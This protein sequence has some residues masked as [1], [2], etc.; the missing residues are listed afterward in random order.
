MYVGIGKGLNTLLVDDEPV[1]QRLLKEVLDAEGFSIEI[2][3]SLAG[4]RQLISRT[5]FDLVIVD[6]NLPD[7]SG[8][9][10][11]EKLFEE[12]NDCA[13]VVITGYANLDSAIEAIRFNVLDYLLK[14]IE[15]NDFRERIR[16]VVDQLLLRREHHKAIQEIDSRDNRMVQ[17]EA[18]TTRDPLTRLYNHAHFQERLGK[19]VSRCSRYGR[20]LGLMFVDIDNFRSINEKLGHN[21]GDDVLK[22]IADILRGESRESDIHFRLREHDIAARYGGDEFV[23]MLPETSK[24]G[25]ATTAERLRNCIEQHD[26]G[27]GLS[28]VTVSIGLSA[29]PVD[30]AERHTLVD[31]ADRALHAAKNFGRNR[32][33]A[34]TPELTAPD[35][36]PTWEAGPGVKQL[37]ALENTIADRA[38]QFVY[39]P[40]IRSR[41]LDVYGY[42]ALCRPTHS[43]FSSPADMVQ[44]A[45]RAGRIIDLGRVLR[46]GAVTPM[47]E[48]PKG[49][50]LFINL[51][52]QE[53]NDP[54]LVA[55][56]PFLQPW[57]DR[58]VFEI[59]SSRAI[60]DHER[61]KNTMQRLR[62]HGFRIALDDLSSGYLGL[63]SVVQLEPDFIKL[64]MAMLRDIPENERA[65][66]LI[67]HFIDYSVGE[68]IEVIA[69]GIESPKDEEI[70]V[71]LGCPLLLQ[72]Y[73]FGKGGPPFP[74]K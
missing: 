36:T 73:F 3:G 54:Q 21:R 7:G 6:K 46:E 64:N 66:R 13:V 25:T 17:L 69:H 14:P 28:R 67:K 63:N 51:H 60:V 18:M 35:T 1:A 5:K 62:A 22:G 52:P 30:G 23:V 70:A 20:V 9:Q 4:A 53:L 59:T 10:L 19:E 26:F 43:L 29:L 72:G 49:F 58:V 40:I 32:V 45:E 61:L 65:Y 74:G 11:A 27:L 8:L 56:E 31:A 39:Q 34:F 71:N 15:V 16:R 68:H 12:R 33:V 55:P 2:A 47:R 38:F 48:L 24:G 57:V 42:E 41:S 37:S 50:S 44:A